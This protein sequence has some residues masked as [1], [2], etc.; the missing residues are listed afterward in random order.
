MWCDNCLLVLPLRGGAIAWGVVI[1][2]YSIAGGVFLLTSGQYFFFHY[3]EWQIYGGIGLGVASVA[4]ISIFA[5]SNKSYIWIQVV[6]FL[7]PFIIVI[8]AIR[9]IIMIVELQR[10]K[11]NITW[12]CNH[13]GQMWSAPV[14]A[15]QASQSSGTVPVGF[16]AAGYSSFN[17]AFIVSLLVDIVF[18]IYMYFLTWRFSKRLEHYA[19]MKGPFHG[20][21]YN[22]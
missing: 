10:G 18:Q 20:G 19:G 16:C 13:G 1:A 5:L 7:W 12:E 22:A 11:D 14:A 8:S 15:A 9:A 3:P 17:I 2:A 6:K 21:Y 4:V